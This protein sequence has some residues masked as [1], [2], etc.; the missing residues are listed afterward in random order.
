MLFL[1]L[2][3]CAFFLRI[4]ISRLQRGFVYAIV[5]I[6]TITNLVEG[7]WI[8]FVCGIPDNNFVLKI[9]AHKC[10]SR[11]TEAGVAYTQASVNAF[12][13]VALAIIPIWL[14]W[15][16]QMKIWTKVSVGGILLLATGYVMTWSIVA[17][18]AANDMN[19]GCVAS[20]VRFKYIPLILE[21]S[22]GFYST[23]YPSRDQL[24][25]LPFCRDCG[26]FDDYMYHRTGYRPLSV[27][28]CYS[29]T[30]AVVAGRHDRII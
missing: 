9:L 27:L 10:V 18:L 3:L 30:T 15:S 21:P 11:W 14:L 26:S 12:T 7:I 25:C 24:I 17:L 29:S 6:S 1:K 22:L 20:M 13:D 8:N 19:S 5:A 2:S 4:L 28:P 23:Y 16:M